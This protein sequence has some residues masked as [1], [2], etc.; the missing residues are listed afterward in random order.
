MGKALAEA[1]AVARATFEEADDALGEMVNN[2]LK[3]EMTRS[4]PRKVGATLARGGF[5]A[6]KKRMDYSEYGGAPLLGVNGG[7]IICHGRSNAKA[8]KNA[9]RVARHFAVNQM[10]TKIREKIGELHAHEF[11]PV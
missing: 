8:I 2:L 9:V 11:E 4:I 3:T 5:G 7:C 10:D 1:S 6:L